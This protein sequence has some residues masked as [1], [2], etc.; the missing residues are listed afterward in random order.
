MRPFSPAETRRACPGPMKT[1]TPI[2]ITAS[3]KI[4]RRCALRSIPT[5][6][7]SRPRTRGREG[8]S[9]GRTGSA[10]RKPRAA[11]GVGWVGSSRRALYEGETKKKGGRGRYKKASSYKHDAIPVTPS[12]AGCAWGFPPGGPPPPTPPADPENPTW[13]NLNSNPGA[14]YF[15]IDRIF[16]WNP[17]EKSFAYQ[18]FHTSRPGALD[19]SFVSSDMINNP[20]T[21]NAVYNLGP[22]LAQGLKW[23]SEEL[24]GGELNN[25]QFNDYVP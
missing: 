7:A 10:G 16:V 24:A 25:K 1:I 23:G 14:Q 11:L 19:T 4:R 22:R 8:P 12:R 13:A 6:R 5:C 9:A 20:R 2:W 18:L 17:E 3:R 15:W 21:M